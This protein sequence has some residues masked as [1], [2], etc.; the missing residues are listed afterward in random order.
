MPSQAVDDTGHAFILFTRGYDR[1]CRQAFS[2]LLHRAPAEA[3]PSPKLATDGIK[4]AWR[5][6]CA[7][8][9]TDPKKPARLTLLFAVD[10]TL[11][12][13][14]GFRY[15]LHCDPGTCNHCASDIGCSGCG[16][17]DD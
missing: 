4:R 14:G 7:L 6:A 10:E 5:H 8:E 13:S 2:R 11:G 3:M 9:R 15:V 17:G 16:G 1:F 12:I